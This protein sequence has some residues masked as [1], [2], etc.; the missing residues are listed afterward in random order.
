MELTQQVRNM[1]ADEAARGMEEKARE[2]RDKGS[3]IYI[4]Q[5]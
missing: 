1:A 2:F 5:E 3:A 4:K